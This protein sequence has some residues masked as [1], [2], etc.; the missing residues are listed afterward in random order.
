MAQVRDGRKRQTFVYDVHGK[1]Q[2]CVINRIRRCPI[3]GQSRRQAPQPSSGT[4]L[5]IR[6]EHFSFR[7]PL[8]RYWLIVAIVMLG[9]MSYRRREPGN[10]R[11]TPQT[12]CK[13]RKPPI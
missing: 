9:E 3:L 2:G 10:F 11:G 5:D 4:H 8:L 12:K 6:N 1:E 7:V 13:H